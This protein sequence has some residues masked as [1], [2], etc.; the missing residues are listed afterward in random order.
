MWM[1]GFGVGAQAVG[2]LIDAVQH[3][4]D[5]AL[6]QSE[7]I[8]DLSSFP[9]PLFFAGICLAVLGA[10]LALFGPQFEAL[11]AHSDDVTVT[12]RIAQVLAPIAA[13]AL[14]AGFAA[15]AGA[16][17]LAD[18]TGTTATETSDDA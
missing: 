5:P 13:V 11:Y 16:S 2:L 12:R 4:D 6:A 18:G 7:G 17:K 14:I 1:V 3:A 8:F 15:A 10:I 9:H